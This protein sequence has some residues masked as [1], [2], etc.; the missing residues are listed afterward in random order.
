MVEIVLAKSAATP[1]DQISQHR[2]LTRAPA[3]NR[4]PET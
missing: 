1:L 3:A 2:A 4:F